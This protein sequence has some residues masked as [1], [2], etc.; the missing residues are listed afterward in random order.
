MCWATDGPLNTH[1]PI[2]PHCDPGSAKVLLMYYWSFTMRR[3]VV[4]LLVLAFSVGLTAAVRADDGD[5]TGGPV[6]S[7]DLQWRVAAATWDRREYDDAA[8]LMQTFA[9]NNP[10][11]GNALEALWRTYM[12]YHAYR[13]DPERKK[14][15]VSKLSDACQSWIHKY[16]TDNKEKAAQGMWYSAQ[17]ADQEGM[18][19]QALSI[20][21]DLV[22]K[23]PGT[24][25]EVDADW[26][27]GEWLRNA[28]R[29]KEAIGY[30]Q[31]YANI[32]K[33]TGEYGATAIYSIGWCYEALGDKQSAIDTYK[34]ML[35]DKWNGK[36]TWGQVC[37]N[38]IDAARRL[39]AMGDAEDCR[40]FALK[41]ID[42]CP[43]EWI[44]LQAQARVLLGDKETKQIQVYCWMH[45]TY[46]G[47]TINIDGRTKLTLS[48]DVPMLVRLNYVTK[49][50]P[51]S[52]T[53][54]VAPKVDLAK[55]PT[56]MTKT[57]GQDGKD[58]LTA[59]IAAPD[60][61][62]GVQGDWNYAFT[63]ADQQVYAPGDLVVTRQ[64]EKEGNGWG[65]C[66]IR[67]QSTGRWHFWIYLPTNSTN[68]NNLSMQPNEVNDGGKTFR[69]YDWYDL[70][71]GM[72]IK[73]PVDVGATTQEYYPR[74]RF[75][76]GI[77][78]YGDKTTGETDAS[79]TTTE[80]SVKLSSEKAFPC[81][82]TFPSD[83]D[84]E[85]DEV[86]R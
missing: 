29:W 23:Y 65:Q 18:R 66:T 38:G 56:N 32:V 28:Q 26:E 77:G 6:V 51:F 53:L 52:G 62:G 84:I 40:R 81:T 54:T 21:A 82:Y 33:E 76:R 25:R 74:M 31:G 45:D 7:A 64:W 4:S 34:L 78:R 10:D 12:V 59:D 86:T 1:T 49:D 55:A 2:L 79:Y 48:R 16:A 67:V 43:K 80:Y 85:L 20:L 11:D 8:N 73:F 68:V 60:K 17:L 50:N 14:I 46:K 63:E 69:W 41:I 71:A 72:T 19:Q 30:Y 58:A 5:N 47:H 35:S 42:N 24:S 3:F 22:K 39:K 9:T 36:W 75:Y 83:E 61:N 70:N 44:D 13:P 27:S 57:T 15:L 37:Y